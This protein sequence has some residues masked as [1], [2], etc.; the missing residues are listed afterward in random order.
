MCDKTPVVEHFNLRM[1]QL[2]H[3]YFKSLHQQRARS[4][5]YMEPPQTVEGL[6]IQIQ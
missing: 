1:R 6:F 3:A 2:A 5:N 4:K